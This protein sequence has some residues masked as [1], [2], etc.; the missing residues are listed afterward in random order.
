ME[1]HGR[2]TLTHF[3]CASR[4][5]LEDKLTYWP[6]LRSG[7]MVSTKDGYVK[8]LLRLT[9]LREDLVA[10]VAASTHDL[11]SAATDAELTAVLL[12]HQLPATITPGRGRSDQAAAEPYREG[13]FFWEL[14]H[15]YP[16]REVQQAIQ[17]LHQMDHTQQHYASVIRAAVAV[18]ERGEPLTETARRLAPAVAVEG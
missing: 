17:Y 5:E 16:T 14:L 13:H 8:K 7:R 15:C 11:R 1:E 6:L 9:A 10:P 2:Q 4:L 3:L 12:H 18:D